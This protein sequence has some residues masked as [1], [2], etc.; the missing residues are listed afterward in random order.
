[1]F[2]ARPYLDLSKTSAEKSWRRFLLQKLSY[3]LC[4]N[5]TRAVEGVEGVEG[6]GG[7]RGKSSIAPIGIERRMSLPIVTSR[8]VIPGSSKGFY[9][10][11]LFLCC[12][13]RKSVSEH[14]SCLWNWQYS[15][16]N[17]IFT[18]IKQ[19]F[20]EID[21]W[22]RDEILKAWASSVT[23]IKRMQK[24]WKLRETHEIYMPWVFQLVSEVKHLAK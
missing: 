22:K 6:G 4:K 12:G 15:L 20:L 24:S 13:Q 8:A 11:K 1:M 5:Q 2:V 16:A 3:V 18:S 21:R 19:A 23:D 10:G 9:R 14:V 7:G 17:S